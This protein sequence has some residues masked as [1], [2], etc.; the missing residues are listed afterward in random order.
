[1]IFTFPFMID[2]DVPPPP[3]PLPARATG[4]AA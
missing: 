2:R 4:L 1:V 3:Q